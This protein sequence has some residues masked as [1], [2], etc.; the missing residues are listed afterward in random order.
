MTT[1]A[2]KPVSLSYNPGDHR[3]QIKRL[4]KH[5]LHHQ[6]KHNI[7]TEGGCLLW[8]NIFRALLLAK[9]TRMELWHLIILLIKKYGLISTKNDQLLFSDD[10]L[11]RLC[12][13]QIY[14]NTEE[15]VSVQLNPPSKESWTHLVPALLGS[16][17]LHALPKVFKS[18][19]RLKHPL[20]NKTNT[21]RDIS[22]NLWQTETWNSQHTLSWHPSM[23][24]R[25]ESI[26]NLSR[27]R[28]WMS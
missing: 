5:T 2:W 22:F 20:G 16:I 26:S 18:Q 6:S 15:R 23:S 28:E 25:W 17:Y 7:L 11:Y 24:W 14:D 8:R 3:S 1:C 27:T 9:C 10:L 21:L 13:Y 19:G 4:H 12:S